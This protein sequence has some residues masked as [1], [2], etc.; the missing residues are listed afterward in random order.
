MSVVCFQTILR[1]PT[2]PAHLKIA[3]CHRN[4]T[5]DVNAAQCQNENENGIES[6]WYLASFPKER[7]KVQIIF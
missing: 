6:Q 3:P 1:K 7:A 5:P 2:N 4:L